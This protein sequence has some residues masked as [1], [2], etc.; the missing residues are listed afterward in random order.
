M[1]DKIHSIV[2]IKELTFATGKSNN[3]PYEFEIVKALA[4]FGFTGEVFDNYPAKDGIGYDWQATIRTRHPQIVSES[5]YRKYTNCSGMDE[6]NVRFGIEEMQEILIAHGYEIIVHTAKAEIHGTSHEGGEVRK[7]GEKWVENVKRIMAVKE[8]DKVNLP[9]WNDSHRAYQLS[10]D[11]QFKKLMKRKLS[12][13]ANDIELLTK[14]I[15]D[16]EKSV[17]KDKD[18]D[19]TRRVEQ[20]ERA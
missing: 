8:D 20:S 14:R 12:N 15:A 17:G 11:T 7:T 9:E 16:L 1:E 3:R 10:F 2:I 18:E 13:P 4:P 5:D 6:W 19:W